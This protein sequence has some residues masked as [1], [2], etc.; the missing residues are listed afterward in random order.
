MGQ[1]I[2]SK[3][4]KKKL[5]N[6]KPE[7]KQLIV[8]LLVD[9]VEVFEDK[10]NIKINAIF[11]FAQERPNRSYK[12]GEPKKGLNKTKNTPNGVSSEC[13]GGRGGTRTSDLYDVNVAL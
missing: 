7:Q 9:R 6:L 4:F 2:F 5:D 10:K 11:R 12:M 13:I 3:N 1:Y 8:E